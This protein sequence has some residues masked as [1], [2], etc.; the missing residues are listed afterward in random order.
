MSAQW[1]AQYPNGQTQIVMSS[2]GNLVSYLASNGPTGDW[3][4]IWTIDNVTDNTFPAITLDSN[5]QPAIVAPSTNGALQSF[6]SV[7][8]PMG[9]QELPIQ[10]APPGSVSGVLGIAIFPDGQ[11]LILAVGASGGL[12]AF[13]SNGGSA[14][15]PSAPIPGAGGVP[16]NASYA[17][18]AISY[19][20]G[21]SGNPASANIYVVANIPAILGN[22]TSGELQ[23][24]TASY[25]FGS[26]TPI[27]AWQWSANPLAPAVTPSTPPVTLAPVSR[28]AIAVG[29]SGEVGVVSFGEVPGG[30]SGLTY[31]AYWYIPSKGAILSLIKP[32]VFLLPLN[33][34]SAGPSIAFDNN[35]TPHIPVISP[36]IAPKLEGDNFTITD[37]SSAESSNQI[38]TYPAPGVVFTNATMAN[39]P[40]G[41]IDL[42]TTLTFDGTPTMN[43]YALLAG[44]SA[45]TAPGE[46]F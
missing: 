43:I 15:M 18:A 30:E 1:I 38:G 27:A 10:I 29:A 3:S 31:L 8:L 11:I 33:T 42:Y 40:N 41:E 5:N 19:V 35:G 24:F 14:P 28:P 17:A 39:G 23:L 9:T 6:I 2:G 22:P 46:I 12:Y 7:T 13:S 32:V 36:P 4:Q 34:V 16:A 25:D 21:T 44:A 20:I 26:H 45:W 37:R